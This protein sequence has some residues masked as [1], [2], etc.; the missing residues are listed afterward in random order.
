MLDQFG[1]WKTNVLIQDKRIEGRLVVLPMPPSENE[2]LA[3]NWAKAKEVIAGGYYS[4]L[5]TKRT[6]RGAVTLSKVYKSWKCASI[7]L[8]KKGKFEKLTG[9]LAVFVIEVF[10][11]NRRRDTD[12]RLKGLFDAMTECEHL[13]EDDS[14]IVLHTVEKRV[15]SKKMFCVAFV[16]PR[17]ELPQ[18]WIEVK[19][20]WLEGIA[21]K[22]DEHTSIA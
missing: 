20:E 17:E 5:N 9:P 2:R 16:L 4:S 13:I 18:L 19:Q 15:I 12:N 7:N 6:K 8:L 10:P 21:K 11:D 14:Q 3:V 1:Q 22:I